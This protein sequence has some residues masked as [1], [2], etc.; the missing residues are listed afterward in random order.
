[1]QLRLPACLVL[2]AGGA[3]APLFAQ[4]A[5]PVLPAPAAGVLQMPFVTLDQERL[6]AESAYGKALL[7][8]LAAAQQQLANENRG[9]EAELARRESELTARRPDMTP[10]AFREL[11]DAFHTEVL[12]YRSA[13]NDKER[14]LYR[15]HDAARLRFREAANQVLAEVMAARGALAVIAEEAIVLGFSQLDITDDAIARLDAV[16]GDGAQ[17]PAPEPTDEPAPA[18]AP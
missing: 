7:E 12:G 5:T 9:I 11:A 16:I 6:F 14:A 17:L 18:T 4:Q 8:E 10:A 3:A 2:L 13:Q 1:M 15:D